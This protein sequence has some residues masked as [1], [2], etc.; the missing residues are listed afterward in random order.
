MRAV[1]IVVL[2]SIILGFALLL[3]LGYQY[4]VPGDDIRALAKFYLLTTY[5]N[6]NYTY[7][8]GATETVTAIVWD[9][10]G[11]DTLFETTVF[12]IA[13]AGCLILARGLYKEEK[14]ASK[15]GSGLSVIVRGVTKITAPMIIVVG[16]SIALHG[17]LTPGG[18]FQGGATMAVLPLLIIVIF[19]LAPLIRRGF[20]PSRLA[21]IRGFALIGIGLVSIILA[22]IG[23]VLGINA[24]VFQSLPKPDAPLGFPSEVEGALMGGILWFFNLFESIAVV[25]AFTIAFIAI[26]LIESR[27]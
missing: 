13:L 3:T 4:L 25:A 10:R 12:Y 8:A 23:L 14:E 24:Y 6:P 7:T 1:E 16:V 9:Y 27:G 2:I 5:F 26:L 17:H 18:G 22:L 19:S 11:L 21:I 15:P 20:T